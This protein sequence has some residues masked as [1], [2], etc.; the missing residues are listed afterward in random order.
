MDSLYGH[1][2]EQ[3][4]EIHKGLDMRD[5]DHETFLSSYQTA[6]RA[7]IPAEKL[8]IWSKCFEVLFIL[9]H[10]GEGTEERQYTDPIITSEYV[11]YQCVQHADRI[12]DE[13]QRM[14]SLTQHTVS[15]SY[16]FMLALR[17][18]FIP[19]TY[20]KAKYSTKATS[21]SGTTLLGGPDDTA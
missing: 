21:W 14:H 2:R 8:R 3:Q 6:L 10:Y 12:N 7:Y 15:P 13:I 5:T 11:S 19:I 20:C 4:D 16:S 18:P 17:A 1:F 9:E